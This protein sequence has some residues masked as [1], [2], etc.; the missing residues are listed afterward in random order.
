MS[1]DGLGAKFPALVSQALALVF[2]EDLSTDHSTSAVRID[3]SE[4]SLQIYFL[5]KPVF[6]IG[7]MFT[8]MS[9]SSGSDFTE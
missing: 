6:S 9:I 1:V 4:Q 2:Y 3:P 8:K 5:D 7:E